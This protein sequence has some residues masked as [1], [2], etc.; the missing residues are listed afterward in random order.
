M[1][2]VLQNLNALLG[3]GL[4][5]L[6]VA[7]AP[8][9]VRDSRSSTLGYHAQFLLPGGPPRAEFFLSALLVLRRDFALR[10]PVQVIARATGNQCL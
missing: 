7:I 10:I 3:C 6:W 2:P 4:G 1:I 8:F 5:V 9:L